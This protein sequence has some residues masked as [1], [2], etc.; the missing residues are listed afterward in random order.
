MCNIWSSAERACVEE[1]G[2]DMFNGWFY[3][4]RPLFAGAIAISAA[5]NDAQ[6][7]NELLYFRAYSVNI[8]NATG[9]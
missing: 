2:N 3:F 5:L 1:G 9:G 8:M 4:N 6:D 7:L